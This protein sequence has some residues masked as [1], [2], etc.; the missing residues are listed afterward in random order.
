MNVDSRYNGYT[1]WKPK[2]SFKSARVSSLDG[3]LW[4]SRREEISVYISGPLQSSLLA[5]DMTDMKRTSPTFSL[6]QAMPFGE[7]I[8]K[9]DA[10]PVGSQH[11]ALI[12][13]DDVAYQC[14]A[15]VPLNQCEETR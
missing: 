4:Y 8:E 11:V 10:D 6:I 3:S 15:I 14:N 13:L 1:Y 5:D 7:K 9:P 2:N 12:M